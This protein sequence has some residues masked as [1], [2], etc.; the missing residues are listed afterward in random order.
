MTSVSLSE[1]RQPVKLKYL[2]AY[3]FLFCHLIAALA[4]FPWFFSWTGVVLFFVGNFVFGVVGVNLTYHRLVSHR[5]F[6]C[7]RWFECTLAIIGTCSLQF[8]PAHW[9]AV[10]RRHHHHTDDE[11]DPHSPLTSFF[12]GHMGWLVVKRENMKRRVL[13][14]RYAKDLMRD[15]LYAWIERRNNWIK[16]GL[17][18]W[19]A[20]FVVGFVGMLLSGA[21]AADA[22]QFGLSLL[23]W[24]AALRTVVVWHSTWSVNSASHL[25]GYRNFDTPDRSHNNFF[26]SLLVGGEWHNNHHADPASARQGHRWWEIDVTWLTIRLFKR[27]GLVTDVVMPSPSVAAIGHSRDT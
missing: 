16:I 8:S 6:S 20:Y 9:A 12:W 1:S 19:I 27:L 22:A 11:H 7:P 24:G 14:D 13:L 26:V 25:W 17:L 23:V 10:H 3:G 4:F 21:S 5:A 15:P 2:E 18:S